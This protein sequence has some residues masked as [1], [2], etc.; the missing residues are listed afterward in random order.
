MGRLR[1]LMDGYYR[2]LDTQGL[3]AASR[4]WSPTC[5]FTAP[6]MRGRGPEFI[7][8]YIQVFYDGSPDLRHTVRRSVETGSTITLELEAHGSNTGSLRL[9]IGEVPPT[10]REWKVSVC[11]VVQVRDGV[12][13]SYHI[14]FDM[15]DFL[16]QIDLLPF[17]LAT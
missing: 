6:G 9:P 8:D 10:G 16:A 4:Y 17:A 3:E 2:T 15:A 14:Y 1:D 13:S 5:E 11:V 7:R 12:F